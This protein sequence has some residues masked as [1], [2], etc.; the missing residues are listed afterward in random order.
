MAPLIISTS[1]PRRVRLPILLA[2]AVTALYV[3]SARHIPF[4]DM[5]LSQ[6]TL[7]NNHP[8]SNRMDILQFVDP[9]IGTANG[10][11][12]VDLFLF[13]KPLTVITCD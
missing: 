11:C 2:A 6:F 10:G 9:L 4:S 3:L 5:P 8:P 1:I 7:L 12:L 13:T